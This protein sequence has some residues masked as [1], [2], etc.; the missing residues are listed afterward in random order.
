MILPVMA[1]AVD[2]LLVPLRSTPWMQWRYVVVHEGRGIGLDEG[3][4]SDNG[5]YAD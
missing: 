1:V 5:I 3:G 4:D 2:M